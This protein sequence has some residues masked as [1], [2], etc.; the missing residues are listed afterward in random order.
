MKYTSA[1]VLLALI[2]QE[3][4]NAIKIKTQAT[5]T[6][7]LVKSLA[8]EM[9]KDVEEKGG[10][11]SAAVQTPAPAAKTQSVAQVK[12]APAKPAAPA[13]KAAPAAAKKAAPAK[14]AVQKKKAEDEEIP[15]DAAAIKA[16][17][18]VIADAAED[19]EPA[20]P[21]QYAAVEAEGETR[22]VNEDGKMIGSD[23]MGSMIQ[24]EITSIKMAS[25]KAAS[26]E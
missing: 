21:I 6:D 18:S 9:S 15:M 25:I 7:D 17:S 5:F 23:P 10:D 8:E 3:Q 13:K 12:A 16:Y 22:R 11:E 14:K 4:T 1:L 2:G 26:D 20:V 24:N 19:S